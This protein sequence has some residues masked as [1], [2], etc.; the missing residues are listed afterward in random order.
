MLIGQDPEDVVLI[1]NHKPKNKLSTT[2]GEELY[3]VTGKEG[4]EVTMESSDG[5]TYRRNS[6]QVKKYHQRERKSK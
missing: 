2:V 3:R 5:V 4:N 6:S 1:K